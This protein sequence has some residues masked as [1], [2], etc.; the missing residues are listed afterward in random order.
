MHLLLTNPICP[1]NPSTSHKSH[2]S[3]NPCIYLSQ[4][5]YAPQIHLPLTNLHMPHK[6]IYIWQIFICPINPSNFHKSSHASQIHASTSHKSHMPQKFMHLPHTN[7]IWPTNPST[8][9]K[10][11]YAPQIH[12][13]LTNPHMPHKSIYLSQIFICATSLCPTRIIKCR[14]LQIMSC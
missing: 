4:I 5:P 8:S 14:H 9:H 1:T 7:P 11:S 13:P 12:L 10:S 6:S 3:Q 2:I